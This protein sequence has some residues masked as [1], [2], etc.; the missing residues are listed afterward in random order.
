MART[1][2][3]NESGVYMYKIAVTGLHAAMTATANPF[4]TDVLVHYCVIDIT[5]ASTGASTFDIGVAAD[6]TTNNDG[7]IDGLSGATAGTFGGI[8]SKGTNGGTPQKWTSSK[9]LNIKEASGDASA[10]VANI[11]VYYSYI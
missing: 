4:G 9:Y 1:T 2:G 11:Y 7:L 6:A 10:M 5:T 3:N 8:V